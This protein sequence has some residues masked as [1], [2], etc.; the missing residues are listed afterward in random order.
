MKP[1]PPWGEVV[2]QYQRR[3]DLIPNLVNT[4][5]GYASHEK[6]TLEAVT[7][8]R[9]AATSFQITRKCSTIPR[10]LP[11]SRKYRGNCRRRCRA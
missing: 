1:P 10:P 5:K 9:A 8:A 3:A 4:V 6:D 11:N 7:R 2:N